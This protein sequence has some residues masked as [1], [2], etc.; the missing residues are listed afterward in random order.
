MNNPSDFYG[1]KYPIIWYLSDFDSAL[2][3]KLKKKKK[4]RFFEE[5]QETV[6]FAKS[7]GISFLIIV[8]LDFDEKLFH[9]N[10]DK[11]IKRRKLEEFEEEPILREIF[12]EITE[13]KFM[14]L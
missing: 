12:N 4:I 5:S 11:D 8:P 1:E 13:T 10:F 6:K 9:E 2:K 7:L 3:K 14:L